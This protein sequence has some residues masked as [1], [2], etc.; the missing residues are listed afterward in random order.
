[1]KYNNKLSSLILAALAFST[2]FSLQSCKDDQPDEYESASGLPTIQY[3]R[4][5]K[6]SAS[7]LTTQ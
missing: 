3:I 2:S 7:D 4:P 1:M 6:A 5:A